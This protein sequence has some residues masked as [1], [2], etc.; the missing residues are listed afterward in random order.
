MKKLFSL[1]CLVVLLGVS[2]N[3]MGQGIQQTTTI[4][5]TRSYWVNSSDGTVA[6]VAAEHNGTYAWSVYKWDGN[7][8]TDYTATTW[9]ATD[10]DD[11][12]FDFVGG[13]TSWKSQI[14]WLETGSYV[15]EVVETNTGTNACT[16][17]RRFGVTIID[18]DLLVQTFDLNGITLLS[19]DVNRCNT[20]SGNIYGEGDAINL[21][22]LTGVTPEMGEMTY[23]YK[24]SLYTLMG[25]DDTKEIT[26]AFATAKWKFTVTN[27]Q[28]LKPAT[29]TSDIT[30]AIPTQTGV[31]GSLTDGSGTIEVD[32]KSIV[33]ITVT[34]K[35]VADVTP[36]DYVLKFNID[37]AS[38]LVDL[39]GDSSFDE[40]Q[41][42][43]GYDG[44]T[45]GSH[46]NSAFQI[47][48]SPIPNTSRISSN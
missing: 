18:L 34:I 15:V 42:P 13:T 1:L 33:T 10:A 39:N 20:N 8:S 43:T 14:K 17:V 26:D 36:N 23:T 28:N 24:V 12:S 40:G 7:V 4:N 21:N 44:T 41:E 19:A 46:T 2:A 32:S 48:V 6:P 3:V 37:P 47:T 22:S 27:T 31:T 9:T 5:S 38:V 25:G 29:S 45:S 30:W 16:T 35:N 11:A